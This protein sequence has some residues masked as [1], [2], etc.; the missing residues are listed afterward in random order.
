MTRYLIELKS[1]YEDTQEQW[2]TNRKDAKATFH[3]LV[4]SHTLF[5][6]D[7]QECVPEPKSVAEGIEIYL[8]SV[9]EG[10]MTTLLES[11]QSRKPLEE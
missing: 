4:E 11:W 8:Y 6:D 9:A 7:A 10:G 5:D 1:D 3:H 2:H